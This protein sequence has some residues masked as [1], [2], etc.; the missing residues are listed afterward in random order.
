MSHS[1]L[2]HIKVVRVTGGPKPDRLLDTSFCGG[3]PLPHAGVIRTGPTTGW[4]VQCGSHDKRLRN[5]VG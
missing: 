5:E 2:D 3:G 4:M 1:S